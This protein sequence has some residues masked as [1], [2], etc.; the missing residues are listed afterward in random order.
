MR[1]VAAATAATVCTAQGVSTA[2][3]SESSRSA[4]SAET[5]L[6]GLRK[7]GVAATTGDGRPHPIL[8]NQIPTSALTPC[9]SRLSPPSWMSPSLLAVLASAR[10]A[11]APQL[12]HR[13]LYPQ[14]SPDAS[15]TAP[16]IYDEVRPRVRSVTASTVRGRSHEYTS[17][18]RRVESREGE[19]G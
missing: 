11:H 12:P 6:Q 1:D 16:H 5:D 15:A 2:E 4:G 19:R 17:K 18:E 7:E 9:L 13:C 3:N 10:G 14:R 8:S